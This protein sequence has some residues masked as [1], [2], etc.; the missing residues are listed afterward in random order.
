[1]KTRRKVLELG[2]KLAA[3]G[4]VLGGL[5]TAEGAVGPAASGT[6]TYGVQM[7]MVR[8]VAAKDLAAAFGLI[9]QA[10]FA[11]VE[12]YPIAYH[13]PAAEL[14]KLLADTGLTAV[15]GHFDYTGRATSVAYAHELG[16]EYLV[17][18][19]LP[20][21]Q[22]LS[23]DGFKQAAAH[24]SGWAEEARRAG[25]Q[26]VFHNHD[27]EFKPIGGSDGW[28]VLMQETDARLV[29]LEL[30]IFWLVT[31]GQQPAEML[32]RYRDRAVLVH[33]KDRLAGAPESFVVNAK[34]TSYCTEL[35]K[36]TIGWPA[37]LQQARAQ[38]I[39]YAYL[40][41]DDTTLPVEQS[42]RESRAYLGRLA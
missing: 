6:M 18:P 12:L 26:F 19:M 10:G 32:R 16:L 39:R 11:Q 40:D 8:A 30:D 25:M 20:E 24:F 4:C 38:G 14:R 23:L 13:Q 9:R 7:F 28:T 37:L 34:A 21:E 2:A 3:A 35:G 36:G 42:M 5:S 17:C 15:S 22:K 31:A 41:Q 1:M 29:K 33:M 27:Y